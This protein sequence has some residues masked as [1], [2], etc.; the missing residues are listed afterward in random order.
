MEDNRI[1][2]FKDYEPDYYALEYSLKEEIGL[3]ESQIENILDEAW[4][5]F[6]YDNFYNWLKQEY[7][8]KEIFKELIEEPYEYL[9]YINIFFWKF[10][11]SR[12]RKEK[13]EIW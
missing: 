9:Y 3:N 11:L 10:S 6:N 5:K 2:Y 4:S 1:W 12:S 8:L 7:E 13:A